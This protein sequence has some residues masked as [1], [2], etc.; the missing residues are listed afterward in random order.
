MSLAFWGTSKEPPEKI[1]ATRL[2]CPLQRPGKASS[3]ALKIWEKMTQTGLDKVKQIEVSLMMEGEIGTLDLFN[4][5]R[6]I[7]ENIGMEFEEMLKSVDDDP[8][9]STISLTNEILHIFNLNEPPEIAEDDE[10]G[11][12]AHYSPI[13]NVCKQSEK[14]RKDISNKMKILINKAHNMGI[15]DIRIPSSPYLSERSKLSLIEKQITS[16]LKVKNVKKIFEEAEIGASDYSFGESK[17]GQSVKHKR[18]SSHHKKDFKRTTL[19]D[20]PKFRTAVKAET[21]RYED[22]FKHTPDLNKRIRKVREIRKKFMEKSKNNPE[23]KSSFN[24]HSVRNTRS[25]YLAPPYTNYNNY[26]ISYKGRTP[27]VHKRYHLP[28]MHNS[29]IRDYS[30]NESKSST[31]VIIES[32]DEMHS[33]NN[34]EQS[35]NML[36]RHNSRENMLYEMKKM[37]NEAVQAVTGPNRLKHS[38]CLSDE[39]KT[40]RIKT[41]DRNRNSKTR[42]S[43]ISHTMQ[44]TSHTHVQDKN[45]SSNVLNE[46]NNAFVTVK[47][48]AGLQNMNKEENK[49]STEVKVCRGFGGPGFKVSV[50]SKVSGNEE[51]EN[52]PRPKSKKDVRE[53]ISILKEYIALKNNESLNHIES[54]NDIKAE[55]RSLMLTSI[56]SDELFNEK[57]MNSETVAK[58]EVIIEPRSRESVSKEEVYEEEADRSSDYPVW[59]NSQEEIDNQDHPTY[60]TYAVTMLLPMGN[61]GE[62]PRFYNPFQFDTIFLNRPGNR[63]IPDQIGDLGDNGWSSWDSPI[64]QR[65]QLPEGFNTNVKNENDSLYVNTSEEQINYNSVEES[66]EESS[67]MAQQQIDTIS[68]IR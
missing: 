12:Y 30:I 41:R 58:T 52:I 8:I 23:G 63:L 22:L 13:S 10:C 61:G 64:W 67:I 45:E 26:N 34:F 21:L 37:V 7:I 28:Q 18:K 27:R 44:S 48:E 20:R 59:N 1:P 51:T 32:N 19:A 56:T 29:H 65:V 2:K 49:V 14:Q 33:E 55:D 60:Q 42:M 66:G 15:H 16:K 62:D 57:D 36:Q 9:E 5:L 53:A 43:S 6:Y 54:R 38:M 39:K 47:Q 11:S 46:K 31:R 25:R 3:V 68:T 24:L 4:S 17:F 50:I 35:S 40:F